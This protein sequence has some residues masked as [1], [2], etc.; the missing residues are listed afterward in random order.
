MKNLFL[1]VVPRLSG[2]KCYIARF[3]GPDSNG[4]FNVSDKDFSVPDFAGVGSGSYR[5]NDGINKVFADDSFELHL[6]QEVD[7]I[8]RTAVEFGVAFLTTEAFDLGHGDTADAYHAE[9]IANLIQ[10]ERFDNRSDFL[11]LIC[12]G[13][14]VSTCRMC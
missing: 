5:F 14:A 8:F 9:C 13:S 1:H 11:Q 4:V 10:Q 12:S 2:L 3:T 6:G 7:N